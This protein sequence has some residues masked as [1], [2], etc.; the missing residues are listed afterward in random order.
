MKV[1]L[2]EKKEN[3]TIPFQKIVSS[4]VFIQRDG[5]SKFSSYLSNKRSVVL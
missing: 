5:L 1:S 2:G 3:L 4:F